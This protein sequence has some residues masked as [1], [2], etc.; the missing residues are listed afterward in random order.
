MSGLRITRIALIRIKPCIFFVPSDVSLCCRRGPVAFV[1]RRKKHRAAES[2]LREIQRGQ[3][4]WSGK[5]RCVHSRWLSSWE[6]QPWGTTQPRPRGLLSRRRRRRLL[7]LLLLLV[8]RLIFLTAVATPSRRRRSA[9]ESYARELAYETRVVSCLLK[10][11]SRLNVKDSE[12]CIL[13]ERN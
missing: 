4:I 7:L 9:T 1:S 11:N 5:R 10:G 13:D 6:P 8:R 3:W 2:S 12:T